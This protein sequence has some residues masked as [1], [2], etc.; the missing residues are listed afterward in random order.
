MLPIDP[1]SA[2]TQIAS[3]VAQINDINKRRNFEQNLAML[4]NKQKNDLEIALQRTNNINARIE[5]LSN[6]VAQIRSAQSTAILTT[7]IQERSRRE[8]T[9]ALVVIGGALAILLGVVLIKKL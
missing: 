1:I 3:T 9:I 4:S 5:I 7:T 6:A 8:R 2:G